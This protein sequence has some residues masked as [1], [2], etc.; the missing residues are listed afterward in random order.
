[1]F[2]GDTLFVMGCGRLFE[3][4]AEQM[5]HSLQ[6]LKALPADTQIYCTHEYTQNNGRFALTLEP[7]NQALQEKM[8]QVAALRANNQP[9]VPS[10]MAEELATNPFLRE[11]STYIQKTLDLINAPPIEIFAKVRELKDRF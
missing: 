11:G 4:T 7:D 2:C 8:L 5:W 9:T 10:T 1:L 3:G 6:K